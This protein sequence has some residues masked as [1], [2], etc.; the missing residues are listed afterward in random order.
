MA[1]WA[2][3]FALKNT[4][5]QLLVYCIYATAVSGNKEQAFTFLPILFVHFIIVL[6]AQKN[7][8]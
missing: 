4:D 2:W 8:L 6:L 7:V 3:V 5:A 1:V